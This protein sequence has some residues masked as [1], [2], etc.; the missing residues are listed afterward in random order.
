[1]DIF[2]DA[3]DQEI[4]ELDRYFQNQSAHAQSLEAVLRGLITEFKERY[5]SA[6]N[7]RLILYVGFLIPSALEAQVQALVTRYVEHMNDR[8][9]PH[10]YL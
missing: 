3:V 5:E 9:L 10:G 1:M 2:T 8:A 4:L 6:M 7:L